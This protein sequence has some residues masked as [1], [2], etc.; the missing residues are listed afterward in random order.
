MTKITAGSINIYTGFSDEA[1]PAAPIPEGSLYIFLD[2]PQIWIARAN[3]WSY[4]MPLSLT[5]S[6][7]YEA[8]DGVAILEPDGGSALRQIVALGAAISGQIMPS[9]EAA[10]QRIIDI[11]LL[12][13][14]EARVQTLLLQGLNTMPVTD[15]IDQLRAQALTFEESITR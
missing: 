13:L 7:P 6:V 2:K 3:V 11:N 4:L 1:L 12:Q 8:T 5:L 15:D 14:T 10:V 9:I